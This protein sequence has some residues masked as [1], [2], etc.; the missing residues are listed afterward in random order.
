MMTMKNSKIN[1]NK[2]AIFQL[3]GLDLN[4]ILGGFHSELSDGAA[5][6]STG[7][8]VSVS[9]SNGKDVDVTSDSDAESD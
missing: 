6:A 4:S 1:L 2:M 7:P 3:S 9:A 8:S 5:S